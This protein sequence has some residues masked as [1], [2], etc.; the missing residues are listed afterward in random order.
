MQTFRKT[1]LKIIPMS[2]MNEKNIVRPFGSPF[3]QY[4]TFLSCL[5]ELKPYPYDPTAPFR[6][7]HFDTYSMYGL[8][9]IC[10]GK[11]ISGMVRNTE[12]FEI[13][14]STLRKTFQC[15]SQGQSLMSFYDSL[16]VSVAG[17]LLACNLFRGWA[18]INYD[19]YYGPMTFFNRSETICK[20]CTSYFTVKLSGPVCNMK[21][22]HFIKELMVFFFGF[23]AHVELISKSKPLHNQQYIYAT[24]KF[25]DN[26]PAFTLEKFDDVP[27]MSRITLFLNRVIGYGIVTDITNDKYYSTCYTFLHS[28]LFDS[29]FHDIAFHF[30]SQRP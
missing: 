23:K 11:V 29:H 2:L 14:Q 7:I 22:N 15:T 27:E 20:P 21:F 16:T 6:M 26:E 19:D 30:P 4:D 13:C 8:G 9:R 3:E 24:F 1:T 5:R 28:R 17:E 12:E 25:K 10:A 18:L